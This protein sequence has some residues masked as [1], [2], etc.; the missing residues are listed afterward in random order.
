VED[1]GERG[2]D[3]RIDEAGDVIPVGEAA[4]AAIQLRRGLWRMAPSHEDVLVL[5]RA[6]GGVA[7]DRVVLVGSLEGLGLPDVF[8]FLHSSKK[9]GAVTVVAGEVCKAMLFE[10]GN[11]VSA[12]SN[13]EEDR[14]G[15]I[16]YRYGKISREQLQSALAEVGGSRRLG[17]VLMDRGILNSH[18]LWNFIR[19]QVEEIFFSVLLLEQGTFYYSVPGH[20]DHFP[21]HVP[22][23]AQELMMEGVRRIDELRYFRQVIPSLDVTLE[24][25]W[26]TPQGLRLSASDEQVLR[27]VQRPMTLR[28]LARA[29]RLGD[30]ET[31]KVVF[32]LVRTGALRLSEAAA[33]V[34]PVTFEE[35]RLVA[36]TDTFNQIFREIFVCIDRAGEGPQ[37]RE[38][39]ASFL[40]AHGYQDLFRNVPLEASGELSKSAI[41]ENLNRSTVENKADYLYAGLNE[42]LFFE[43]FEAREILGREE[44]QALMRRVNALF[45][46]LRS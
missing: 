6:D 21:A 4:R 37:F 44:E 20:P 7:A 25:K 3:L 33:R 31:T 19:R 41:L 27:L 40:S 13:C 46:Q 36:L 9:S 5:E 2:P 11:V 38:G 23:N 1:S 35:Q 45:Q 10:D 22:M 39:L 14:L 29:S 30:F 34:S 18:E 26:P 17:K 8:S 42:L 32:H 24:P 12:M 43:I 16:L 15:E 28:E